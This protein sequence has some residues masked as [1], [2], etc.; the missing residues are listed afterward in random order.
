GIDGAAQGSD[1]GAARAVEPGGLAQPS[2][3]GAR[4]RPWRVVGGGEL[5]RVGVG[6]VAVPGVRSERGGGGRGGAAGDRWSAG[7]AGG[8]G[9]EHLLPGHAAGGGAAERGSVEGLGSAC[10]ADRRRPSDGG[11]GRGERAA[12]VQQLRTDGVHGGGDGGRGEEGGEREAAVDR[13]SDR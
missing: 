6:A 11:A 4:G 13:T 9:S 10:A 5:R 12:A 1:G 7:V 8:A 2:V 3:R